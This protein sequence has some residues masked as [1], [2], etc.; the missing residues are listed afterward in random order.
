MGCKDGRQDRH[1]AAEPKSLTEYVSPTVKLTSPFPAGK[2]EK[3]LDRLVHKEQSHLDP[4]AHKCHLEDFLMP[5]GNLELDTQPTINQ[6]Y[7]TF[8]RTPSTMLISMTESWL[9]SRL[10]GDR[11]AAV[12][13]SACRHPRDRYQRLGAVARHAATNKNE[14]DASMAVDDFVR[15]VAKELYR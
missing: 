5:T 10:S 11:H 14:H 15:K 2:K 13:H 6:F 7:V 4:E 8:T 12:T 3:L 1:R 9:R